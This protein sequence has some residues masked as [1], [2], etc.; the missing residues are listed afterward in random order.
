MIESIKNQKLNELKSTIDTNKELLSSIQK[1]FNDL[2]QIIFKENCHKEYLKQCEPE[3]CS[4]RL[5]NTCNYSDQLSSLFE[6][7]KSFE[8][9]F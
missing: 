2:A 7:K 8:I 6:L 5:E 4:F 1:Q 3:Y 9:K